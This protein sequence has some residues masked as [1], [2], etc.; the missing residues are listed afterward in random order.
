VHY[1]SG[2]VLELRDIK[3]QRSREF[4]SKWFAVRSDLDVR[5]EGAIDLLQHPLA[6]DFNGLMEGMKVKLRFEYEECGRAP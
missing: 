2:V 5:A 6:E 3:R 1:S 4:A